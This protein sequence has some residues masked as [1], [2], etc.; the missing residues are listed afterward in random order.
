MPEASD[1][2]PLVTPSKLITALQRRGKPP[3]EVL[4]LPGFAVLTTVYPV[5]KR[6]KSLLNANPLTAWSWKHPPLCV[7][8]RD[9][10]PAGVLAS[11]SPGAPQAAILI[12]ELAAFGVHALLFLGFA[13]GIGKDRRQGDI[14]VPPYAYVGEGTSKYYG[15]SSM[16]FADKRFSEG[17][18][19]MFRGAGIQDCSAVPAWST[20]ALYRETGEDVKRVSGLGVKGVDMETS[21]VFGVAR[22]LAVKAA[23][24]LWISDLLT[25]SEWQSCFYDARFK[26][27]LATGLEAVKDFCLNQGPEFSVP[28]K[29]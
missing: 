20:D 3:G 17:L 19:D 25:P 21:A 8:E 1:S 11:C 22:A 15:A 6:L 5:Y 9:G 10:M 16:T 12:E 27:A 28:E 18:L 14:L 29:P 4:S 2:Q 24:V 26:K 7:F 13:G 23:A